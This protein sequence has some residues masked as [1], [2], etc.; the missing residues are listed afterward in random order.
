[1]YTVVVALTNE[2]FDVL[3]DAVS[4]NDATEVSILKTELKSSYTKKLYKAVSRSE[5]T[6]NLLE[7]ED[8]LLL[9]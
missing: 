4:R 6:G 8:Q 1:M 2:Y 7:R 9:N 3:V 5:L